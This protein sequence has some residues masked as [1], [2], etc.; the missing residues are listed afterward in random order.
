MVPQSVGAA[1]SLGCTRFEGVVWIPFYRVVRPMLSSHYR[2]VK[3]NAAQLRFIGALE[4]HEEEP[5]DSNEKRREEMLQR[6]QVGRRFESSDIRDRIYALLGMSKTSRG[7]G[8]PPFHLPVDYT[9]SA[10]E[11]FA[12]FARELGH[13]RGE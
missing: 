10:S 9:I 5:H 2:A 6:L 7:Y 11:V 8:K 3:E 13:D 1:G 4:A 12:R